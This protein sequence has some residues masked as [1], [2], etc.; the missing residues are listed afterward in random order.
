MRFVKRVKHARVPIGHIEDGYKVGIWARSQRSSYKNKKKSLSP[1]RI[2]VLEAVKGWVWDSNE[3]EWQEGFEHLRRF[4]KRYKHARV[5]RGHIE[6][7]YKLG[8]W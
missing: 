6:D 1:D 4:V 2:R 8:I 3:A 5:P 7:G